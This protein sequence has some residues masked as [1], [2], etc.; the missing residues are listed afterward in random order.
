MAL[1]RPKRNNTAKRYIPVHCDSS[2]GHQMP[3]H[4]HPSQLIIQIRADAVEQ[5]RRIGWAKRSHLG[6]QR[7]DH[8]L[9]VTLAFVRSQKFDIAQPGRANLSLRDD[10]E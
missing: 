4:R 3:K 10:L 2:F 7:I 9:R 6:E 8:L 5:G 1:L